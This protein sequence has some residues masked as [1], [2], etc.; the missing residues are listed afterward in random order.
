MD[1]LTAPED[2]SFK[3]QYKIRLLDITIPNRGP[4][5]LRSIIAQINA[6]EV[7]D[8][9]VDESWSTHLGEWIIPIAT[10]AM[11]RFA[12]LAEFDSK[13]ISPMELAADMEAILTTM[14]PEESE[15]RIADGR[16]DAV[17]RT[18]SP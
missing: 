6:F 3:R 2:V 1:L 7:I 17:Y 8:G 14:W 9:E 16:L 4:K 10:V 11:R 12:R 5:H 15:V 13:T 18:R